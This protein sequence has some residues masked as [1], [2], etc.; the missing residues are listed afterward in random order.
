MGLLLL[1]LEA[2]DARL[3]LGSMTALVSLVPVAVALVAGGPL[4]GVLAAAVALAGVAALL[5]GTAAVVVALRQIAPGLVL[6]SVLLRRLHLPAALAVVALTSLAAT[7]A[8][9]WALL[10]GGSQFFALLGRQVEAQVAD[11]DRLSGRLGLA[12]EPGLARESARVVATAMRVAG[13][14]LVT[15]GLLVVA[16]VNLVVARMCLRRRGFRAFAEEAVPDH[17]VW[18]VIAAGLMLVSQH[19]A[20]E[21]VGVNLLVVMAPLY[22][23]QGLAVLRHFFLS[24]RVPR[25]L[26][27]VGFGLFA[28]QP[29]LLVAAACLGLS[30]LWVDF[31][32]IRSAA[33]PA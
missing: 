12:G 24:A 33:T 27:G 13:P 3:G 8:L 28:L 21:R 16:L 4:A 20:I 32:K 15:V 5:G 25:P 29:L 18:G 6:G 9:A 11:L 23:I 1:G 26:Q 7:L 10:P 19:E 14:G 17:L 22:A 2:A 31:R 30:D